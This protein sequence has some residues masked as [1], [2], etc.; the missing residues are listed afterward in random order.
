MSDF[1]Q[2]GE[3]VVQRPMPAPV[4]VSSIL[5]DDEIGRVWRIAKSLASSGM[6]KDVTQ[7][8]QAFGKILLGRDLGLSPTQAL[9]SIDIVRGNVQIR[10]KRLLA[11]VKQSENYDYEVLERSPERGAIRF[12]EKSKRT[13]DWRACEP[14][15]EFTYAEAE[16]VGL[17]KPS[18]NGEPSIWTKWPANMCLWRC[19]SIGVN[20]HCPDLTGGIPVYTEADSFD[21]RREVGDSEGDGSEPGW[22]GLSQPQV[23]AVEGMIKRAREKGHADL[24][25][26]ATVQMRVAGQTPAFI[27]QQLAA[28]ASELEAMPDPVEGTVEEDAAREQGQPT[29]AENAELDE[30]ARGEQGT[31]G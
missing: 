28:W 27:D 6:F 9:L 10:G 19:A 31:L 15:I 26:R 8:E 7:A 25:D 12:F 11:W 23:K 30:Q 18:R 22:L 3:I 17:T 5:T 4:M 29:A 1:D 13:G 21:E 14:D 2:P 16:K 24:S 20:L